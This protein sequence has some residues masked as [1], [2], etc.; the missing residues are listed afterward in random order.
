M[1]TE[2]EGGDP[3]CWMHLFFDEADAATANTTQPPVR[4]DTGTSTAAS[5]R[6]TSAMTIAPERVWSKLEVLERADTAYLDFVTGLRLLNM[7]TIRP[8]MRR[9]WEAKAKR[10]EAEHGRPP[11]T[12]DEAKAIMDPDPASRWYRRLGRSQQEMNWQRVIDSAAAYEADLERALDASDAAG[13]GQVIWDPNFVYPEYYDTVEYHIQPGSYHRFPLA[14]YIYYFGTR[15]FHLGRDATAPDDRKTS[16][17]NQTRVPADGQV[18]RILELACSVGQSSIAWKKRF[19]HAEVWG[20]DMGAPMVRY[21]HTLAVQQRVDVNF[22]QM[23]AENITF[24]DNHFDVVYAYILFHELP[25][26]IADQV[27]AEAYRV[28]RPGGVFTILDFASAEVWS[29]L[30]IYVRDYDQHSNGEPY[31]M[32]F[33]YWDMPAAFERVGFR[34]LQL[35]SQP[36]VTQRRFSGE[37]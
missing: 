13:P 18:N 7:Q 32:D 31:S 28:L 2:P 10:F 17:V 29:A 34:N 22:K 1:S 11:E 23:A 4:Y 16:L 14:G 33:C 6:R 36:D 30:D 25:T 8:A 19:P 21:A 5:Q 15:V 9:S 12:L 37:K 26:A 35:E 27:V 3:P 20:T 24:P